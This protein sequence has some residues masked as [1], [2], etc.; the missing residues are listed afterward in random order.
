[1]RETEEQLIRLFMKTL[2]S[3]GCSVGIGFTYWHKTEE[4]RV[5]K[6]VKV[7]G[8]SLLGTWDTPE[9]VVEDVMNTMGLK[10]K[11]FNDLT[12]YPETEDT[13]VTW[14]MLKI[15]MPFLRMIFSSNPKKTI[16]TI[17]QIT[18]RMV[19]LIDQAMEGDSD[20]ERN[21]PGSG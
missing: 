5:D 17:R 12:F 7:D 11:N 1:M 15:D 4:D 6:Y 16:G 21:Q 14:R 9:N 2:L 10:R 13:G 18:E 20:G 19:D 3:H 8:A